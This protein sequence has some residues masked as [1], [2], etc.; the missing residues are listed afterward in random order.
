M[1]WENLSSN[2]P[3][4]GADSSDIV[5]E[6]HE[7]RTVCSN[8]GC[9]ISTGLI[10]DEADWRT[11][12]D[13]TQQTQ[14][15][16]VGFESRENEELYSE[17][18]DRYLSTLQSHVAMESKVDFSELK[19]IDYALFLGTE[20]KSLSE[21]IFQVYLR[22]NTFKT[23]NRT[24]IRERIEQRIPSLEKPSIDKDDVFSRSVQRNF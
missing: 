18:S 6:A 7:G 14:K 4:C 19:S 3:E 13:S 2:C 15:D 5:L 20:T 12:G 9:V 17:I 8:C 16:R 11:F 24:Q 23:C 10:S 21:N 1:L 22:F